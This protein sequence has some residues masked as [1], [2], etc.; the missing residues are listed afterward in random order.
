MKPL[1]HLSVVL[2]LTLLHTACT[3][4]RSPGVTGR[5]T[6]ARTDR[7]V[8]GAHVGFAE[9]TT[10]AT[11]TDSHGH[12][13]LPLQRSFSPLPMFTF[14]FVHVTLQVAHS[15]NRTSSTQIAREAEN[16]P[17]SIQLQ[18]RAMI[19]PTPKGLTHPSRSFGL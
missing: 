5:V 9:F 17:C 4:P 3:V 8:A 14:E 11:T 19:T 15:G 10:P 1:A 13:H 12:F 18:T 16:F 6:D 7:A 2:L